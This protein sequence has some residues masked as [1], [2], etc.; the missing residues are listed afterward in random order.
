MAELLYRSLASIALHLDQH[1]SRPFKAL[2]IATFDGI[3]W[4]LFGSNQIARVAS[5]SADN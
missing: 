2:R 5:L 3:S 1:L 4:T